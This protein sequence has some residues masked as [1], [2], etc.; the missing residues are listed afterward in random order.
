[1]ANVEATRTSNQAVMSALPYPES[2]MKIAIS[3]ND[4]Q[5]SF[6]FGRGVSLVIYWSG[7]NLPECSGS[8]WTPSLGIEDS[9]WRM[10][11]S[12]PAKGNGKPV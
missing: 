10:L 9:N 5:R 11:V 8:N 4:C 7:L 3:G 1:M 6:T 12:K 2:S